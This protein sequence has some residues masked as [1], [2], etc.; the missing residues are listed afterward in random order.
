MG[1]GFYREKLKLLEVELDELETLQAQMQALGGS[2][3]VGTKSLKYKLQVV[4]NKIRNINER[5]EKEA[6]AL[7][8]WT[9]KHQDKVRSLN[10]VAGYISELR[11]I[12]ESVE[13]FVKLGEADV[14]MLNKHIAACTELRKYSRILLAHQRVVAESLKKKPSKLKI[15]DTA[16]VEATEAIT[17][18]IPPATVPK[19]SIEDVLKAMKNNKP[20]WDLKPKLAENNA[21]DIMR[22]AP[23]DEGI[24]EIDISADSPFE[25]KFA[26][27]EETNDQT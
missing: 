22:V 13:N 1:M 26:S 6:N 8:I 11:G 4:E 14:A 10:Q 9:E 12:I 27:E 19:V 24:S 18:K 3:L 20:A 23:K 17:E 21:G 5:L 2:E 16:T 15:V 25:F 7:D